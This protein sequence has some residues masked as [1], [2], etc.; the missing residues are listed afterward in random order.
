[1]LANKIS[2]KYLKLDRDTWGGLGLYVLLIIV[3]IAVIFRLMFGTAH[4][5]ISCNV[6]VC[7]ACMHIDECDNVL[8][9]IKVTVHHFINCHKS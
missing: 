2:N 3:C 8:L 5:F 1:M 4:H 9:E 6:F 7:S